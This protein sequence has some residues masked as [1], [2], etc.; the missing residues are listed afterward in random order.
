MFC[1]SYTSSREF[2]T[3]NT[4]VEAQMSYREQLWD[5]AGMH[6]VRLDLMGDNIWAQFPLGWVSRQGYKNR[7]DL[8]SSYKSAYNQLNLLL[9]A[10]LKRVGV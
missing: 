2:K 5:L 9:N 3:S 4:G 6:D 8:G 1:L 7:Y 10:G